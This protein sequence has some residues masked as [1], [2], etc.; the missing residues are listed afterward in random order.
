MNRPLELL[1]LSA[2]MTNDDD[3]GTSTRLSSSA[4]RRLR[5]RKAAVQDCQDYDAKYEV[6]CLQQRVECLEWA[7]YCQL[8]AGVS[9]QFHPPGLEQ[10]PEVEPAPV[11]AHETPMVLFSP[12]PSA[13]VEVQEAPE[14]DS[15]TRQISSLLEELDKLNTDLCDQLYVRSSPVYSLAALTPTESDGSVAG[16]VGAEMTH[17]FDL[18]E[19]LAQL[20]DDDQYATEDFEK[21]LQQWAVAHGYIQDTASMEAAFLQLNER[22]RG[23]CFKDGVADH[24]HWQALVYEYLGPFLV[25]Y[26]KR[27]LTRMKDD[28]FDKKFGYWDGRSVFWHDVCD[29]YMEGFRAGATRD[30]KYRS[31]EFLKLFMRQGKMWTS[32]WKELAGQ[33]DK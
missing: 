33:K 23:E 20:G 2:I 26:G 3:H 15:C 27:Q 11:K 30:P 1:E 8:Q 12:S 22:G 18:T 25:R 19:F 17:A 5:S 28:E 13:T 21:Y 10:Q 24:A 7:I 6:F 9:G 14:D 29:K 4:K 16:V 31:E 32:L